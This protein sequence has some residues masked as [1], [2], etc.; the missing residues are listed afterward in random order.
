M[1]EKIENGDFIEID[2]VGRDKETGALFDLT[3]EDVAKKE[4]I[5]AP[6]AEFGP[7]TI[8]VGAQHVIPGLDEKLTTL[9]V[10]DKSAITVPPASGFGPRQPN[11]VELVPRSVFKRQHIN[12]MP[13]MP[14]KLGNRRGVVKTVSGG[15][16]QVDFNHPLAGKELEYE[17]EIH[18]K[19]TSPDEKIKSLL[20]LHVPGI[21]FKELKINTGNDE[22]EITTPR[23]PKTR[24]YINLSEENI[25]HDI[26][27]YIKLKKVKFV[28]VFEENADK[29]TVGGKNG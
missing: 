13:G 15:R 23:T 7:V 5:D 3:R 10:G 22:V 4:K 25:A 29:Q 14:V 6:N 24:R 19:I 17:V 8:V 27:T 11:L 21:D 2:Y 26:L 16:I 9:S 1:A 18:K 12:P 20:S 28:D